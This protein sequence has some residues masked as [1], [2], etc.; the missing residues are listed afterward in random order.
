MT[1]NTGQGDKRKLS[2]E[3]LEQTM[4]ALRWRVVR[5][6]RHPLVMT[7][8]RL[9]RTCDVATHTTCLPKYDHNGLSVQIEKCLL[10]QSCVTLAP[11]GVE[12]LYFLARN[13]THVTEPSAHTDGVW[14]W[15]YF[16]SDI[17]HGAFM[18]A[19]DSVLFGSKS[20]AITESSVQTYGASMWSS[21]AMSSMEGTRFLAWY[22]RAYSMFRYFLK[23]YVSPLSSFTLWTIL[24]IPKG[25]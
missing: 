3:T 19:G 10:L 15:I 17:Q 5:T 11:C 6:T 18:R 13:L 9:W 8:Q 14:L 4:H 24:D 20:N 1:N 25:V 7:E 16:M 2:P 22:Q 23:Q 21:W 12:T